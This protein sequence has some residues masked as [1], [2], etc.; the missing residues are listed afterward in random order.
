MKALLFERNLPRFAASRLIA[1]AGS[2]KG[3]GVGPLRLTDVDEP[4]L[5]GPGWHRVRPLLSGICGSDLALLDGKSSRY[6][7]PLVS[8]PFVP[9]HE[10]VGV[11]EG[12]PRDGERV[13]VEAVLH[14]AVRGIDPVCPSCATGRTEDCEMIAVGDLPPGLQTG[15][16]AATGGGW[17]GMLVA[18][19]RQL[20]GV[21]EGLDDDAAV[22]IEPT[23]CALHA[24]TGVIASVAAARLRDAI[25]DERPSVVAVVGAG[26]LG[27]CTIAALNRLRRSPGAPPLTLIVIAKHPHQERLARM[28]GADRVAPP[29]ELSRAVRRATR[30]H[31]IPPAGG[32]V[33]VRG[34]HRLAGGADVIVDCAASPS[35]FT[36]ALSAVRPRGHVVLVGMP[37]PARV[38]LAPLWHREITLSGAYAYG[39][40]R[41]DALFGAWHE[42]GH[43]DVQGQAGLTPQDRPR[44]FA[45]AAEVVADAGLGRLVSARYAIDRFEDAVAHAGSAGRRGAVKIVFDL[46]RRPGARRTAATRAAAAGSQPG[47]AAGA[48]Q[49]DTPRGQGAQL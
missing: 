30:T 38:D 39:T 4:E 3:A 37:G 45:L 12:G 15:Y 23:A 8:F 18:H 14:C 19:D 29:S 21:P 1:A 42:A 43:E 11:V 13:A 16:C 6:F 46:R 33:S 5:P 34:T 22:M 2:G 28:L 26:T 10:I 36:D 7:E 27:L 31:Q 24:A 32:A 44:T 49:G 20:F 25:D 35:S 9:G 41:L 48:P 40:E 47:R 17:S